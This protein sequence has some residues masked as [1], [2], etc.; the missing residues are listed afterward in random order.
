M[1]VTEVGNSSQIVQLTGLR[2]KESL[3][4]VH[5]SVKH[6]RIIHSSWQQHICRVQVSKFIVNTNSIQM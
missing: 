2:K 5:M 3:Q 1:S 6:Q 4:S